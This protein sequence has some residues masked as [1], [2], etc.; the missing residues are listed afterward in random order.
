MALNTSPE[1]PPDED[2]MKQYL[3]EKFAELIE[4]VGDGYG[5]PLQDELIRR[6]EKT[7]ADFDEDVQA[8]LGDLKQRS[9]ERYEAMHR[10]WQEEASATEAETGEDE[11]TEEEPEISA[12]EKKLEEREQKKTTPQTESKAEPKRRHGRF[13]LKHK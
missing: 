10:L 6:L 5:K 2:V 4:K 3:E 9:D 1:T 13:S 7:I 12:W 11:P 8:L